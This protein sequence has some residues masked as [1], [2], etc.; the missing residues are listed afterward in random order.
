MF[1]GMYM[2]DDSSMHNVP[3]LVI[4][5][6]DGRY[7]L[8]YDLRLL[9]SHTKDVKSHIPSYNWLFELL[10]GT[11]FLCLTEKRTLRCLL[12]QIMFGSYDQNYAYQ[13]HGK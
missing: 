5:R 2:P 10:Q 7:R 13:L 6:K 4:P 11:H 8:A 12:L 9:N 3:V 1:N